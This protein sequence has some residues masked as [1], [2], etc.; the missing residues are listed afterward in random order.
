MSRTPEELASW[1]AARRRAD[2]FGFEAETVVPY[3]PFALARPYLRSDVAESNWRPISLNGADVREQM[4]SYMEFAWSKVINHRGVSAS[5]S[6]TKLAT[7]CYV[8]GDDEAEAICR[9]ES[10][11]S[12]YGAPILAYL[13]DR[14]GFDRPAND[15]VARMARGQPC[16]D[17]CTE[18]CG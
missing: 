10:R 3:L 11:Y 1:Y 18:G 17:G 4:R 16:R 13:C 6:V 2:Q 12:Q 14:F 8:L 9:D 5:R 7:W 15:A